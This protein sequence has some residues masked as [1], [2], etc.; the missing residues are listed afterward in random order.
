MKSRIQ[1]RV[2]CNRGNDGVNAAGASAIS[3][4][5]KVQHGGIFPSLSRS[6]NGCVFS[7]PPTRMN[8]DKEGC[9]LNQRGRRFLAAASLTIPREPDTKRPRINQK[10][11][12]RAF[13]AILRTSRVLPSFLSIRINN[14]YSR[15]YRIIP[16]NDN[17]LNGLLRIGGA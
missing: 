7:I 11:C 16:C 3:S 17:R 10:R 9:T 14:S 4:S 6:T 15:R 1:S 12:G 2:R 8:F 5:L 13:G